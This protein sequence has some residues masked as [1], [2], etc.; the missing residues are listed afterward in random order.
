MSWTI[1]K[2][3]RANKDAGFHFFDTKGMRFFD[4]KIEP[5]VYQ[6]D[7]G[8]YFITSEQFHPDIHPSENSGPR[9]WTVRRFHP[10]EPGRIRTVGPF[11]EFT[12]EEA[13]SLA[14]GLAAGFQR[15]EDVPR[16]MEVSHA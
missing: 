13:D 16:Q 9:R 3:K 10:E 11:C 6:G 4:S 8:V 7:G 5:K 2:I 14:K 15:P 12:F 1:S